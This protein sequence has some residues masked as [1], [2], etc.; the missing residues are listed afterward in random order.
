MK[1]R[2]RVTKKKGSSNN[3]PSNKGHTWKKLYKTIEQDSDSSFQVH[4]GRQCTICKKTILNAT[5]VYHE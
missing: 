4:N 2:T 5:G 1:H 3:H